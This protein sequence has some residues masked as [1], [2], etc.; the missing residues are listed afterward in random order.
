M[1]LPPKASRT[2]TI[3]SPA[4]SAGVVFNINH[5]STSTHQPWQPSTFNPPSPRSTRQPSFSSTSKLHPQGLHHARHQVNTTDCHL[6][7]LHGF[8]APPSIS[9]LAAAIV[10]FVL[11]SPNSNSNTVLAPL[12]Y[13]S[14]MASHHT[15]S[16]CHASSYHAPPH[17]SNFTSP[18]QH[19]PHI[20]TPPTTPL[21]SLPH[22]C[23]HP[24]LHAPQCSKASITSRCH[25]WANTLCPRRRGPGHHCA[26]SVVSPRR[27]STLAAT[28]EHHNEPQHLT[29][30]PKP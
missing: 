4:S 8:H 17:P 20:L 5:C 2:T 30:M 21:N 24:C 13:Q 9:S 16:R 18:N 26:P 6:V 7:P 14:L 28:A 23:S 3:T 19:H 10:S 1:L 11:L 29:C 27:Q 12:H 25:A 22:S 15:S